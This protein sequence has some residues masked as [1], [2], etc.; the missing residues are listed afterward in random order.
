MG[1]NKP[2]PQHK[3]QAGE[4]ETVKSAGATTRRAPIHGKEEKRSRGR[5]TSSDER[6]LIIL[7]FDYEEI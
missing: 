3:A 1:S 7:L 6:L 4:D 2:G 5:K